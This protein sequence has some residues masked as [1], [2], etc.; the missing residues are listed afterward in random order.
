MKKKLI[1]IVLVIMGFGFCVGFSVAW[2][3]NNK[4]K[5]MKIKKC[6]L[7]DLDGSVTRLPQFENREA[8]LQE[9]VFN[10]RLLLH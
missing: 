5:K 10:N 6:W 1:W 9:N 7:V 3:L 8:S 2:L 4:I